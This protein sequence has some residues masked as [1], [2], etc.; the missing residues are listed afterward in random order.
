VG[1][2]RMKPRKG[3]GTELRRIRAIMWNYRDTTHARGTA[4][5]GIPMVAACCATTLGADPR[6]YAGLARKG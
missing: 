5:N 3:A 1:A 4:P 6:K 2:A